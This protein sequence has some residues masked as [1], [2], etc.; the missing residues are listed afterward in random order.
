VG[1]GD[2][3]PAPLIVRTGYNDVARKAVWQFLRSN[4]PRI[5]M[6]RR[7]AAAADVPL[8]EPVMGPKAGKR[9]K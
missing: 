9:K 4:D 5:G 7:F 8:E 2:A 1:A 3:V 6:L